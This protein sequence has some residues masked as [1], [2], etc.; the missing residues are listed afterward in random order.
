MNHR[1]KSQVKAQAYMVS[2]TSPEIRCDS[3]ALTV[4]FIDDWHT[5][6]FQKRFK[7]VK[8]AKRYCEESG[9]AHIC[10]GIDFTLFCRVMAWRQGQ[11]RL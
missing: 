2:V 3:T 8:E 5:C 9:I 11:K 4:A 10:H 7:T 1:L 6:S